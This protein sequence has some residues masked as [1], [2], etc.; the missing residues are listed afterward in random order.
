MYIEK[1]IP[2]LVTNNNIQCLYIIIDGDYKHVCIFINDSMFM[3]T[4]GQEYYAF[5]PRFESTYS[6]YFG[7]LSYAKV[8]ENNAGDIH[9]NMYINL[10]TEYFT[11]NMFVL[12]YI[13]CNHDLYNI[14]YSFCT[15]TTN[16]YILK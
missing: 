12:K 14:L 13:D 11:K 8:H 4:Y 10:C 9:A 6:E 5:S 7:Y 2:I 15:G 16:E 1:T 3:N